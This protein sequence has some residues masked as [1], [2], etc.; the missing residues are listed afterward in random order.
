[1]RHGAE[2]NV[3]DKAR[4]TCPLFTA[5]S[6]GNF[7][8]VVTLVER[9]ANRTF[10]DPHGNTCLHVAASTGNKLIVKYLLE[11]GS[12]MNTVNNNGQRPLD[13]AFAHGHVEAIAA[14][15]HFKSALSRNTI[16]LNACAEGDLE[17][18]HN[19]FLSGSDPKSVLSENK[20]NG[21]HIACAFG[22]VEVAKGLADCG[23]ELN[24]PNSAGL[25]PFLW[26]CEIGQ[27]AGI[28]WLHM[29]G[30][31]INQTV[32]FSGNTG[33]HIAAMHAQ[34]D[35]VDWL[36]RHRADVSILNKDGDSALTVACSAGHISTSS[37]LSRETN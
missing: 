6:N 28:E 29:N 8:L 27:V 9:S 13:I 10:L 19:F 23:L 37:L 1:L 21:L 24:E 31:D 30:V 7:G 35:V 20:S 2:P 5:C 36:L 15:K 11:C 22:Q 4:S 32:A 33:L 25:T 34:D 3:T 26:C 18:L 12:A 16:F 17:Y 14:F